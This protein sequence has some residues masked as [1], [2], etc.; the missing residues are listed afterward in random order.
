[1]WMQN[2]LVNDIMNVIK[3]EEK[4]LFLHNKKGG[5]HKQIRF[6]FI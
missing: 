3:G 2:E 5:K 6:E 1:M 4:S